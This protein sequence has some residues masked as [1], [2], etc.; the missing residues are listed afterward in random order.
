[1]SKTIEIKV[2]PG[3]KKTFLKEEHG[4]CKIYLQAPAVEGKANKALIDFLAGHFQV[5]K[6]QIEIIKGLHSRI[7]TIMIVGI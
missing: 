3:A 7:K 2:I 4:I 5:K 6:H 1:M